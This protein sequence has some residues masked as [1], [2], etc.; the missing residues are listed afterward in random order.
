METF[1]VEADKDNLNAPGGK[2]T[3]RFVV[4]AADWGTAAG[5]FPGASFRILESGTH[6]DEL[7]HER[8]ILNGG[9]SQI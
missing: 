1:I 4:R 7:A 5:L 9:I 8:G 3:M 2:E 6:L